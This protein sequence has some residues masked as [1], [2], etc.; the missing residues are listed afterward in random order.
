MRFWRSIVLPALAAALLIAPASAEAAPAEAEKV[1]NV[2]GAAKPSTPRSSV[3]TRR[4]WVFGFNSGYA[5][6]RFVGT[7]VPVI[8]ELRTDTPQEYP[9]LLEGEHS[10]KKTDIES[11]P[12]FQFRVGYAVNPRLMISFERT[13]W[14]KK[15]KNNSWRFSASTFSA[16][17][18]PGGGHLFVRG[19]AGISALTEKI[20]I[21]APFF[22]DA[23]DRGVSLEGAA[24][25]EYRLWKR[26]ALNP[27]ISIR[28]MSYGH[29]LRSQIGAAAMG[30]N[31]WF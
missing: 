4:A 28:Q 30:L 13:N 19:G 27:E 14:Y 8:G 7:W 16:T 3:P 15:F 25:Y 11:A 22:I 24:G 18:Y 10:W 21:E 29:S 5:G 6:A 31:W 1:A 17:A 26:V 23:S 12:S 20:P 2:A 9:L